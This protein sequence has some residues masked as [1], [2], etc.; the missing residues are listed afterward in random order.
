MEWFLLSDFRGK[1]RSYSN[2]KCV[3]DYL[4][5]SGSLYE[6]ERKVLYGIPLALKYSVGFL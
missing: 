5:D 3:C 1:E 4:K 6:S 2:N